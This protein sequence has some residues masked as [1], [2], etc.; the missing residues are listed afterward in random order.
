MALN[1]TPF[2]D[3][4]DI[5]FGSGIL[6]V[7]AYTQPGSTPSL[8]AQANDVGVIRTATLTVTR[9]KLEVLAGYPRQLLIAYVLQ[10]D[11]VFSATGIEWK[12]S[13]LRDAL[14]AGRV[15]GNTIG[16]GGSTTLT[17]VAVE[18]VHQMPAGGT[19]FLR[20][21]KANGQG[22]LTLNFGDDVQE[23]TYAFKALTVTQAWG[24]QPL[25]SDESYF[26]LEK[27]DPPA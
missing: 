24:G 10:E 26:Q 5:G 3:T 25:N 1:L 18:F 14:A 9:Q 7:E 8:S 16:F 23:F 6:Y 21:W 11:V 22:D 4:D 19:I 27:V 13:R 17:E 12:I 2:Y 20:I 15:V